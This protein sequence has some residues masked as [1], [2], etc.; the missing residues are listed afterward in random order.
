M[1]IDPRYYPP[2]RVQRL[3]MPE[4]IDDLGLSLGEAER[5]LSILDTSND[6]VN[7]TYADTHR[8]PPPSWSADVFA[9]AAA[10]AGQ[11]YTPYRGDERVRAELAGTLAAALGVEVDPARNLVVTPGTQGGLFAALAA[12]VGEGD[13]VLLPDPDYLSTERTIRFLNGQ[14]ETVPLVYNSRGAYL[15]QEALIRLARR[16]PRAMVFSNPN[17]PTGYVYD[18]DSLELIARL[19][20]EYGITVIVDELYSRLVYDQTPFN[21]LVALA[22]DRDRIVT[23]LGPS[24]TESLSGYRI[25]CIVA[26]ADISQS[27]EDI[28]SITALRAPAYAQHLLAHWIKEDQ[29]YVANRI[30]E[31]QALRDIAY[32]SL[33]STGYFDVYLPRGTSYI[34]PTITRGNPSGQLVARHLLEDS[35][36][37]IN[38][39][40]QFGRRSANSFRLCF[41]QDQRILEQS[42][43]GLIRCMDTLVGER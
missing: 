37:I 34:F 27:I 14:I 5:E 40:Y 13:T 23:L 25:G 28:Q 24:K 43:Q 4:R 6:F 26:S 10:G 9:R 39:G 11:T 12:I 30:Q 17:N 2:E 31:Y 7:L 20:A 21:H 42:L 22:G 3:Q 18:R 16:G 36:L 8:F 1:A 35:R 33:S 29:A 38:P 41:A 32:K 19:S 15:D